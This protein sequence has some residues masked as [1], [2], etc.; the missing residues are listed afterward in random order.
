MKYLYLAA[1]IL[2]TGV[3]HAD[4]QPRLFNTVDGSPL[5]LENARE[6]GRDT[7]AVKE[8][9]ETGV[10]IYNED[11]EVLEQGEELF[12][13]MCSGCHGHY[14]EGKVGPGINQEYWTYPRN[15]TDEGL[16]STIFAGARGQMGPMWSAL[17]LDEMLLTMAWVR[18]LYT[19]DAENAVWLTPEQREEFTP[20]KIPGS[21]ADD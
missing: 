3:V 11:P 10:N 5:D 20:F 16:F 17:T 4:A 8:F 1:I 9:M 13:T 19:E 2:V 18:H 21:G 7:E 14:G 6:E 15:E 12:L